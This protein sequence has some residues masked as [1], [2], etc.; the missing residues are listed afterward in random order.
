MLGPFPRDVWMIIGKYVSRDKEDLLAFTSVCKTMMHWAE[1]CILY[2]RS[3]RNVTPA[4]GLTERKFL[5]FCYYHDVLDACDHF[6]EFEYTVDA[7][8]VARVLNTFID[9]HPKCLRYFF[10]QSEPVYVCATKENAIKL[11]YTIWTE[12][13]FFTPRTALYLLLYAAAPELL[14]YRRRRHAKRRRK[15]E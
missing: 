6:I 2:G 11:S 12:H 15:V 13:L 1:Q 8:D 7:E 3:P 5:V 4:F 14:K 10:A 9:T